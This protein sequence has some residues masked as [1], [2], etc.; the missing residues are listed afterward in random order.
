M[1]EKL[2]SLREVSDKLGVNT[3]TLGYRR[4]QFPEYFPRIGVDKRKYNDLSIKV[5]DIINYGFDNDLPHD[6]IR[7][8]LNQIMQPIFEEIETPTNDNEHIEQTTTKETNDN[9]N[10]FE[11]NFDQLIIAT[12][13]NEQFNKFISTIYKMLEDEKIKNE[14]IEQELKDSKNTINNMDAEL[15]EVKDQLNK[16]VNHTMYTGISGK[17]RKWKEERTAKKKEKQRLKLAKIQEKLEK[18]IG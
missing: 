16:L 11:E 12:K 14:Y 2:Y 10:E 9:E 17:F 6:I 18:E 1:N 5:F 8:Q 3:N 15:K 13:A 4:N 7:Q